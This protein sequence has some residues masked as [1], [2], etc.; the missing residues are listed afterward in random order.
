S[1]KQQQSWTLFS[2][3]W[4]LLFRFLGQSNTYF[5]EF[6]GLYTEK[7]HGYN[8]CSLIL[9]FHRTIAAKYELSPVMISRW[10][11]EFLER[12]SMVFNAAEGNNHHGGRGFSRHTCTY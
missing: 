2:R 8:T 1:I 4:L 6:D 5:S 3:P 7:P 12:A 11:A 10:K 9:Y